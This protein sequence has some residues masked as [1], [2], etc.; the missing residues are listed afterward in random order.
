MCA[1]STYYSKC[2][3]YYGAKISSRLFIALYIGDMLYM[4]PDKKFTT[5]YISSIFDKSRGFIIG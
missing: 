4:L 3:L 5:V 1:L 2:C